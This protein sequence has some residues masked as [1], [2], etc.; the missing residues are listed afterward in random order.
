[1]TLRLKTICENFEN[2]VFLQDADYQWFNF[3]SD[4]KSNSKFSQTFFLTDF[5][6]RFAKI[7]ILSIHNSLI[8][9]T[10]KALL[11]LNFRKSP[12]WPVFE[13]DL[14]KK[15]WSYYIDNQLIEPEKAF[16]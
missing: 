1:M 2:Q 4:K 10:V 9:N 11:F 12:F 7:N 5:W 16:Y 15:I 13:I 14:R 8:V 6:N 3:S